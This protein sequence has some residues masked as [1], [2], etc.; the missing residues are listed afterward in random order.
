MKAKDRGAKDLV[1]VEKQNVAFVIAHI[2]EIAEKNGHV[3]LGYDSLFD[4]C[5]K[6]L[7]LSE[8]L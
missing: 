7:K 4:Y 2:A 3:L 1:Q 8:I 6:R 5:V